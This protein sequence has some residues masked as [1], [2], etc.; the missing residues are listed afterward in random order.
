[1]E[2][3][4]ILEKLGIKPNEA[5]IYS[6][7]LGSG[8]ETISSIAKTT[9][10]HRPIIYKVIPYLIE[11]GLI[12][13]APKGKQKRFSAESPEKLTALLDQTAKDLQ[14]AMP[15]L[16]HSFSFQNKK[17]AVKFLEGKNSITF[18]L[19]DIV[20]SM[21]KEDVFFRYSSP[22]DS[23]KNSRY[24]PHNYRALRDQKQ[25]QRFVIAN[26]HSMAGK[27]PRLERSVKFIPQKYGL[28]DYDIT[29][30]IYGNKVA[31]VDYN[32]TTSVIIENPSIAE[33]QKKIFKLLYDLL[34]ESKWS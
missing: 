25:L 17:P 13:L 18:V 16:M 19:N 26:E 9:G 34:P 23:Q 5:K 11:R 4:D 31:F 24:L 8:P 30:I 22:K 6:A 29:Q 33:F 14:E 28:F 7:L 2:N 1:M 15:D 12:V 3:A 10:L 32:T 21:K 20:Q 27:K